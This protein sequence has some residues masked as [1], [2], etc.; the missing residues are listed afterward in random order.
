VEAQG[1]LVNVQASDRRQT[2]LM[3]NPSGARLLAGKKALIMGV[4]DKHSI[5]WGIARAMHAHGAGLAFT[6]QEEPKGRIERNVRDLVATLEGAEDSLMVPCDVADDASIES[7]FGRVGSAWRGLDVLVHAIA[8]AD[9]DDLNRPFS[10]ISRRGYKLA[11][12]ISAYSLNAATRAAAPLMAERGG[13]SVMTLT[14][15]AVE[16]AVP[17]YS[18]MA[19]AKA[20]LETGVR[21]LA[22]EMGPAKI[23]VNAIS[24]G[25]V[26][27]LSASAVKGITALRRWTEAASPLR[28]NITPDDVGNAAVFLASDMSRM[29]TGNTIFVDSG[30]H[31]LAAQGG[32]IQ[33]REE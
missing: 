1:G 10:E 19:A 13:G 7:L 28:E 29:V 32:A 22:A 18:A 17:G 15:N 6:Y 3:P 2:A 4:A 25:P 30:T 24:A 12:E 20:A 8:F 14:Y 16:K 21:Y 11:M 26:R 33:T 9:R 23:R 5:A 27:T 31:V